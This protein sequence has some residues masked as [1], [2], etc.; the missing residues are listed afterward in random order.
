MSVC[1]AS[2][3]LIMPEWPNSYFWPFINPRSGVMSHIVKDWCVLPSCEPVFYPGRGQRHYKSAFSGCP[4]FRL[5]ALR[6][7]CD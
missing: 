5:L 2:G 3:T 4:S 7:V 1:K 6:L